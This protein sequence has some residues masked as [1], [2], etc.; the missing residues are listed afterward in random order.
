MELILKDKTYYKIPQKDIIH[1]ANTFQN[2]DVYQQIMVMASW[3]LA[4]P[5]KRKTKAGINR[6]INSWLTRANEKGSS[7][8]MPL[9]ES[10]FDVTWIPDI[11]L[12]LEVQEYYLEKYG[13]YFLN[14][15]K[16]TRNDYGGALINEPNRLN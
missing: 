6:F 5:A 7:I 12:R 1:W 3:C 10:R 11:E 9:M 2:I 14:G 8:D 15:K 16:V 4:N 13:V